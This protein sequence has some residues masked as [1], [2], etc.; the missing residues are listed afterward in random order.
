[1]VDVVMLKIAAI[2]SNPDF[3]PNILEPFAFCDLSA[4]TT[5]ECPSTPTVDLDG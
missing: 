3:G 4:K 2:L 5:G 1:M